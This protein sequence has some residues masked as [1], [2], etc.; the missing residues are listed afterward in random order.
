VPARG[1]SSARFPLATP[2]RAAASAPQG[3]AVGRTGCS[4]K[5]VPRRRW[6]ERGAGQDGGAQPVAHAWRAGGGGAGCGSGPPC[7]AAR[8]TSCPA[9]CPSC[10]ISSSGTRPPTRKRCGAGGPGWG[11]RAGAAG[12]AGLAERPPPHPPPC[13][14]SVPAAVPPLPVPCG[15]LH[16]PA[17]Q[18]Q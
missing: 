10:R 18:A 7:R 14:C 13:V 17:G 6:S 9:T 8:E 4:R 16:L 3:G 15:D 2:A 1:R 12:V 5:F 11:G